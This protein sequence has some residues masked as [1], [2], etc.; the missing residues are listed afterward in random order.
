MH[1]IAVL[2]D[3]D[4]IKPKLA[5]IEEICLS[6]GK[7][8]DRRAFSNTPAVLA[9]YGGSFRQFAYRFELTP[10][11]DPVSQEVD[12]LIERAALEIIANSEMQ[13]K[14]IAVVSNDNGYARLFN[15]LK[16]R[17][18][19]TLAIGNQIGNKLR[20][21]ADYIEVLNEVMRPTYVGID[22]G[23]TNTVMA[24]ANIAP[25]GQQWTAAAISVSVKD[26][27]GSLVRKEI[28]PSSVRFNTKEQAEVGGHV[29]AQAYAFRDQTILAWKHDMGVSFDGQAFYYNLTS[30]KIAPEE[31]AAKVLAFCR[32]RL[33]QNREVQGAVITHPASYESDAIEATRRAAIIAGWQEEEV[34]LLPE[35]HAALYDFL[36]R[37][38]KGEIPQTFDIHQPN[39][40]LVYDLGGG[41]L[42]VTLHCV[43]WQGISNQFTIRDLAVGSRTR[44]GGDTVDRLIAEYILN[45]FPGAAKLSVADQKK[46]GYEL[47]IYAEKFK[48]MWG[49]EYAESADKQDFKAAFQGN[50]L[51]G[52]F[53]I[54]YYITT[55]RMREILAPL[56]CENINLEILENLA[57][58]RAFDEPPFTDEFNSFVVPVL[59]ILLK[60]KQ[61]TGTL[62]K[63][64]TVLLNGGMTYF[65]AVRDRLQKL[66]KNTPIIDDG[67]PDLA[68]ARGAA[69]FA[70]GAQ[71]AGNGQRVNPT[72]IYLEVN[73]DGE[74]KLTLIV[75]Q[76]QT[77][78]YHTIFKEK[79]K[80]PDAN[81]GYLKFKAWV[82]MGTK[83][84]HNTTLQRLRQ[85]PIEKLIE[86][87]LTPGS[88]LDVEVE[89]TFDERLLLALIAK[90]GSRFQLEV[91]TD[92][93]INLS[94]LKSP[95]TAVKNI[96]L[97]SIIPSIPR[98]RTGR[99]IPTG[100]PI[101]FTEWE[102]L[103]SRLHKDW[104]N[105]GLWQHY[106]ELENQTLAASNR[107]QIIGEFL[108]WLETNDIMMSSQ[109]HTKI[110][111]AV[112][113][114][115]SLF[116]TFDSMDIKSKE[117]E[118]KFEQWIKRKFD[119]GLAKISNDLLT[120]MAETPGKLLW[121][122]W[123]DYLIQAF[124]AHQRQRQA[125][126]FFNSLAKCGRPSYRNLSVLHDVIKNS[127]HLG[128]QEKAVWALA[129]L[130]SPGQPQEYAAHFIDVERAAKL[131]LE[132]LY[133]YSIQ[134]QVAVNFISCL[135]QCVAWQSKGANLKPQILE[136]VKRLPKSNLPVLATLPKFPQI[137]N[138]FY[139][140]LSLLPK[141]LALD[142]ASPE[143]IDQ[144]QELLLEVVKE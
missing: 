80:L 139:R 19:K 123:D 48:K 90:D 135:S 86:A 93:D 75:A 130:L 21:T 136:E 5:T 58:D 13:V 22:L 7:L 142:T 56:L 20:E 101:K 72:N 84:N 115:S 113:V 127:S 35:P 102:M 23:T 16:R 81:S 94:P 78:P 44:V 140:K 117:L 122:N 121:L 15:S 70:A 143:E 71:G 31:A 89:Y 52:E 67:D 29:K 33:L 132:Q 144:I 111:L 120:Y 126:V 124:S 76:G 92:N 63:V 134:P 34:V 114:L 85:V 46:L 95:A 54:R 69:L 119:N 98:T 1:N 62:P 129:R 51:E 55:E 110:K 77:Y 131:S 17:G 2:L 39:N 68:V 27:Y 9:A 118:K 105:R 104:N 82:G 138:T 133:N 8:V 42:D 45:N 103:A 99:Q 66:F 87:K 97:S 128:Q 125:L 3:L 12:S 96:E 112:R 57:V 26:E 38:Q 141:M 43:Q 64:D 4:N 40:L 73:E 18:I 100:I 88:R 25:M 60:V 50:F 10:G 91:S 36:H 79:F 109:G 108:K 30:G 11:L 59:E 41:T 49:A 116:Q 106:R 61:R 107:S 28:I 24:I 74:N 14:M 6:H 32:D 137:E 65:P 53:P 47:R 83:P 37:L